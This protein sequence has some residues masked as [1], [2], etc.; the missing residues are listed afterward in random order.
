MPRL[1]TVEYLIFVHCDHCELNPIERVWA[2]IKDH[3][4]NHTQYNYDS[5][6]G[7]I[8]EA[9]C[10]IP[11]DTVAKYWR[12]SFRIAYQYDKF[13]A[14]DLSEIVKDVASIRLSRTN[15]SKRRISMRY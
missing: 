5:M 6:R 14:K 9:R 4:R 10:Q 13:P 7:L 1:G 8:D 11:P 15:E 3:V 12:K 2:Y